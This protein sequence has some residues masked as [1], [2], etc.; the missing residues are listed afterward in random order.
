[1]AAVDLPETSSWHEII[2][3]VGA[4]DLASP[5]VGAPVNRAAQA[6][7]DRTRYLYD[8][9]KPVE[10]VILAHSTAMAIPDSAWTNLVFHSA[11]RNDTGET[12]T[13]PRDYLIVPAG[14]TEAKIQGGVV[15]NNPQATNRCIVQIMTLKNG[16]V[17]VNAGWD[18]FNRYL[19]VTAPS[20]NC[21]SGWIPVAPNDRLSLA[22][23]CTPASL[24][25][26]TTYCEILLR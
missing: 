19:I 4:G 26:P 14:I 9:L 13:F 18:A 23:R 6:L 11:T 25:L 3:G 22:V 10:S 16:A 5:G 8:Q 2:Q 20:A 15:L 17:P 24:T 12:L 21:H 1:M 7:A